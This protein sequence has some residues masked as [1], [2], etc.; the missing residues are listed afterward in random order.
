MVAKSLRHKFVSAVADSTDTTLVRSQTCWNDDHNFWLGNRSSTSTSD[1]LADTDHFATINYNSSSPVAVTLP[2]PTGSTFLVGWTVHLINQGSGAVTITPGGSATIN[3]KASLVLAPGM[4]VAIFSDGTN[5]SAMVVPADVPSTGAGR[6]TY[7][8][9]TQ[10]K[11]APY[12]GQ[13]V[14]VGGVWRQIPSAGVTGGTTG[15]YV[16]G[17][18]G[19]NLVNNMYWVYLWDN[20]GTPTVDYSPNVGHATSSTAGNIGTEIKSGD[21]SRS[22]IG[23]VHVDSS[24]HFN[25]SAGF[26][27]VASWSNRCL[28]S[29]QGASTVGT[30]G[31]STSWA[32][33]S[34]A[35]RVLLLSFADDTVFVT[36]HGAGAHATAGGTIYTSI[37]ANGAQTGAASLL[38]SAAASAYVGV[39]G[40]IAFAPS[41][42]TMNY[43]SPWYLMVTAGTGTFYL[44]C[45]GLIRG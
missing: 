5:Y 40:L 13:W 18:S 17:A 31:T 28:K 21:D 45:G 2:A 29:V 10:I 7:V 34:T 30:S 14:K 44:W 33:I 36:L 23:L 22:L 37:G 32:E 43:F 6:L 41:E 42:A 35:S 4:A 12:N 27:G 15:V 38:T 24:L 19:Q 3:A 16:N 8:S 1:T 11:F 25:D 9:S 39:S 26:R 20:A